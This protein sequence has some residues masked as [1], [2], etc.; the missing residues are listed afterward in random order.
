MI[1]LPWAGDAP[2]AFAD[3]PTRIVA[4]G[5]TCAMVLAAA[6]YTSP[7]MLHI[8]GR[9]AQLIVPGLI[10]L[11]MA[12]LLLA[13]AFSDR[14]GRLALPAGAAGR[15]AGAA[16][17]TIGAFLATW[18]PLHLGSSFGLGTHTS[19]TEDLKTTGPYRLVRHPRYFGLLLWALGVTLAFRAGIGI[20]ITILI[21]IL[22]AHRAADEERELRRAFGPSWARYAAT[23]Q[24]RIIPLTR[25][26]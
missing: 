11:L 23:T 18:A 5:A 7:A 24:A 26:S 2:G 22:L 8:R 21:G 20:P 16:L 1:L 19:R 10:A 4:A 13:A 12:A 15:G 17:A 14:H 9:R 3:A 25:S 6:L